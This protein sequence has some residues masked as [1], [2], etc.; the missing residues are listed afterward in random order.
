MGAQE[1]MEEVRPYV[2]ERV[3]QTR[4]IG[5]HLKRIFNTTKAFEHTVLADSDLK[6]LESSYPP[7]I[8]RG[9]LKMTT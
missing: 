4:V 5:R 7:L 2:L 3:G 9:I 1:E 6:D 8:S